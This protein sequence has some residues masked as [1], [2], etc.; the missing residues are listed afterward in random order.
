[1]SR[2][3]GLLR[4]GGLASYCIT[5]VVYDP[6]LDWWYGEEWIE[7]PYPVGTEIT[8]DEDYQSDHPDY[9]YTHFYFEK[10]CKDGT[11]EVYSTARTF[12]MPDFPLVAYYSV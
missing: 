5:Y 11:Q 7:G 6:N 10:V 1:M 8:V 12:V 9:G 2:R 3:A 4:K